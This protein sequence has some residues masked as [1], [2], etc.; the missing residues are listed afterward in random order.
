MHRRIPLVAL[1]LFLATHAWAASPK[2]PQKPKAP[3]KAVVN[4]YWGERVRDDYQYMEKGS[5]PTTAKWA[6]GQNRYTRA[7]LDHHPER[8]AVL[9][10]VVALTHSQSPDYYS[11]SYRTGTY[12][13]IKEEGPHG[14]ALSLFEC[15]IFFY[16]FGNVKQYGDTFRSFSSYV[17]Y[18]KFVKVN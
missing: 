14:K 1:T 16:F 12:F 9:D 5:D 15:K 11:G 6:Q 4:T 13:F 2:L 8:K 17:F 3:K 18:N 7:W 10:R